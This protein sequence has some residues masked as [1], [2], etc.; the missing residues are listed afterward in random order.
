MLFQRNVES[1]VELEPILRSK[2]FSGCAASVGSTATTAVAS[3]LIQD[4]GLG[5]SGIILSDICTFEFHSAI[6]SF[7]LMH[8]T[9]NS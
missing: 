4:S 9:H 3:S 6:R 7:P 5:S 1:K 8:I 2:V